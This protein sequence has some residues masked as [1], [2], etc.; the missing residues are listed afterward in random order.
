MITL[1]NKQLKVQVKELGAEL[2]SIYSKESNLEYLWQAGSAWPK[3]APVLFPIVGQLKDNKYSYNGKDYSL[4]RHGFAR[5]QEFEVFDHNET[6]A[7]FVLS[8]NEKTLASYPFQFNFY[9]I[10]ELIGDRLD[11]H[12]KVENDGDTEMFYSVGGHPAFNI[13]LIQGSTYSDYKLRFN[14]PVTADRWL[15]E[16]GF[17]SNESIPFFEDQ[18][19][20]ELSKDLFIDDALVFKAIGA[21]SVSLRLGGSRHGFTMQLNN[22][23]YLGI[24]A[25]KE[26]DFICI[27]P[28]WGI[29]DSVNANGELSTKEGILSLPPEEDAMHSYSIRFF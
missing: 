20:L 15:L 5:E 13:P 1:E 18:T 9:V 4:N 19:M 14:Q 12:Y 23:P 2:S 27:E 26:A 3:Q 10:Y 24:W 25:A 7:T 6:S 28:W 22:C 16:N 11:V 17:I 21:S 29:A 8:S